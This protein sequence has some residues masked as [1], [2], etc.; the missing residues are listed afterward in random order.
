[1]THA[2]PSER[3][4]YADPAAGPRN[5]YF[6]QELIIFDFYINFADYTTL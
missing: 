4:K 5:A 3:G 1:M 2:P 6:D